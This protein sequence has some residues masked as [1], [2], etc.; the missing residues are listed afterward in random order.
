MNPKY[1]SMKHKLLTTYFKVKYGSILIVYY[2]SHG[3]NIRVI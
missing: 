3:V 2:K 1:I